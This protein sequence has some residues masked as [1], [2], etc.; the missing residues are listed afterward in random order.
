MLG[1]FKRASGTGF[2]ANDDAFAF[3]GRA[4][5]PL[6]R[7]LMPLAMPLLFGIVNWAY[8]FRG[9]DP[10]CHFF[11][12][13][14]ALPFD[15]IWNRETVHAVERVLPHVRFRVFKSDRT[16]APE[17]VGKSDIWGHFL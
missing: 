7:G 2:N 16:A 13:I 6:A 8:V 5:G 14:R 12:P 4:K 17:S 10:K 1:R 11:R 3:R 15:R 9:N